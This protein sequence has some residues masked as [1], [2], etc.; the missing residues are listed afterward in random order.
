MA[1][2]KFDTIQL[3]AGQGTSGPG[4]RCESSSDLCNDI[5]CFSRLCRCRGKVWSSGRRKYL[6][7]ADKLDAGRRF[8]KK[9]SRRWKAG[10]AALAVASGAAAITPYT[11]QALAQNGGHIVSQKT[12]YGGSYNLL[13]HTLPNLGITASFVDIHD[14]E[15]VERAITEQTKSALYRDAR[16]SQRDIPDMD[17]LAELA[18]KYQIPLVVDNTFGTPYWIRPIEHGADIVVH[19]ATK[20]LSAGTE[21]HLEALSLIRE[22][23]TGKLRGKYPAITDPNDSYHGVVFSQATPGAAFVTYIRAVILRDM[24]AAISPLLHFF[25]FRE[26]KRSPFVWNVMPKIRK[27]IEYLNHHPLC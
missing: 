13:T 7:Q 23:L 9:G 17:A 22:D 24:G 18:H 21:Q 5:I 15:A 3:H 27:V 4:D 26:Q 25:C 6:R 11:L 19:S 10:S 12:I 14:L 2:Y 20:S 1:D 8:E 16:Q